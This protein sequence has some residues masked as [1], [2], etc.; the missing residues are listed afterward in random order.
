MA[1][2]DEVIDFMEN[3]RFTSQDIAYLKKEMSYAPD[4]FFQYLKSMN[5]ENV[6][7]SGIS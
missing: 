1:G 5:L 7:I 4:A 3:F 2:I 6:K